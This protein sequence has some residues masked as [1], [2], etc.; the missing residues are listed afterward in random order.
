MAAPSWQFPVLSLA[1]RNLLSFAC[2]LSELQIGRKRFPL[3]ALR[4][5]NWLFVLGGAIALWQWQ[6]LLAAGIGLLSTGL[7][8]RIQQRRWQPPWASIRQF[9]D[10][11]NRRLSLA[12]IA[13]GVATL[14]AY[15][16]IKVWIDF[17]NPWI[18][19]GAILQGCG[20]LAVLILLIWQMAE[21]HSSS[22]DLQFN[23]LVIDLTYVDPLKRLIAVRQLTQ[24][25]QAQP[26]KTRNMM[27]AEYFQVMLSRELE[28]VVQNAILDGLEV[29]GALQ[30]HS[31]DR[32]AW[33]INPAKTTTVP[34][35]L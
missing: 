21:R 14:G 27:I 7:T 35:S 2:E 23:R 28:V 12:M 33:L 8:Y 4:K 5:Q 26:D 11:A 6:L 3:K 31:A 18:A 24:F 30:L 19:V 22:A 20:T 25:A 17:K 1:Q 34:E 15:L 32:P 13:G 16:A 29:V 10:G 9:W